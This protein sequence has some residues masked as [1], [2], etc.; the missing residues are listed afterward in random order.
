MGAERAGQPYT[1]RAADGTE[2]RILLTTLGESRTF[3]LATP[4]DDVA[5]TVARLQRSVLAVDLL[6][7]VIGALVAWVAVR[8]SL[9]PLDR[10]EE[11]AEAIAGGDLSGGC[12]TRAPS[13]PRWGGSP[14]P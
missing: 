8:G 5:A 1:V 13:T 12:P 2:W 9:R 4:I 6:V 11:T 3:V 10:I 14:V 7:L